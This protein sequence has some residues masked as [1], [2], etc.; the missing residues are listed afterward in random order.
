M[1][2]SQESG[3]AIVL[4][5]AESD[6]NTGSTP[7]KNSGWLLLE[8]HGWETATE[9][10]KASGRIIDALRRSL[11]Y[12]H[13]GADLGDRGPKSGFSQVFLSDCSNAT[14]ESIAND[15]PGWMIFPTS[16][17]PKI[18]RIGDIGAYRTVTEERFKTTFAAAFDC[19]KPMSAT[20][21]TAFELYTCAHS[22]GTV[23]EARFALLF[24]TLEVLIETLPRSESARNH[25]DQLIKLTEDNVDIEPSDRRSLVGT[26]EWMRNHSIRQSGRRLVEARLPGW[27]HNGKT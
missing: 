15:I 22:V 20:E 3:P 26:L 11:A 18:V 7:I 17:R 6:N 21:R 14:G 16:S 13:M 12:H 10:E 1:D 9:A 24:A 25:V 4:K 8:S 2:L 19:E 27:M 23:Q 5:S